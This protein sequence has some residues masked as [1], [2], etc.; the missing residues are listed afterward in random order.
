MKRRLSVTILIILSL[1]FLLTSQSHSHPHVFLETSLKIVFDQEGLAG[2]RVKWLFDE[3]FSSMIL[4]DFDLNQDQQLEKNEIG[5]IRQNAFANLKNF[6]YFTSIKINGKPFKVESVSDF[7][8]ALKEN[9][10]IYE[11]LI[12]CHVKATKHYKEFRVSQYD[13]EYYSA[14]FYSKERPFTF[15]GTSSFDIEHWAEKNPDE[16]YYFGQIVPIELITKFKLK[17]G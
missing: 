6:G 1:P 9:Q 3:M 13:R 12:P 2:V 10:L 17:S 5:L 16:S 11:F 8:A 7:S 4:L 15:E 14:V